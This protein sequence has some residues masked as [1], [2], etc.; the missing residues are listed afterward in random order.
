MA[1]QHSEVIYQKA[2][3]QVLGG[4]H[5]RMGIYGISD[6]TTDEFH[7]EI[8]EWTRW[9]TMLS[10]LLIYNIASFR[11]ELRAY[12][13]GE[14]PKSYKDNDMISILKVF[15]TYGIKLYQVTIMSKT[16][17]QITNLSTLE[18]IEN[19]IIPIHI[20][21]TNELNDAEKYMIDNAFRPSPEMAFVVNIEE[22]ADLL[23]TRKNNL[24]QTLKNSYRFGLQHLKT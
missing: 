7:A 3:E 1:S 13:F 10:Q 4:T 9:R 18:V 19:T 20:I 2:L 6:I 14:R 23:N 24:L 16:K 22:V 5:Q 15:S 12:V 8:K 17:I 11:P 21:P